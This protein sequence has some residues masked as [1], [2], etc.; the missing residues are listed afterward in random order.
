ME[1]T[2]SLRAALQLQVDFLESSDPASDEDE[3]FAWQ[4]MRADFEQ[5]LA[6]TQQDGESSSLKAS[7]ESIRNGGVQNDT[8]EVGE[9]S[10]AE[11]HSEGSEGAVKAFDPDDK[12]ETNTDSNQL[13][14]ESENDNTTTEAI[15]ETDGSNDGKQNDS[16]EKNTEARGKKTLSGR[17]NVLTDTDCSSKAIVKPPEDIDELIEGDISGPRNSLNPEKNRY[18]DCVGCFDKLNRD[19]SEA[20]GLECGH[21]WCMSCVDNMFR[22]AAKA[23]ADYPAKCC[24]DLDVGTVA[25]TRFEGDNAEPVHIGDILGQDTCTMY[26]KKGVEFRTPTRDRVYCANVDCL[27][28]IPKPPLGSFSRVWQDKNLLQCPRCLYDTCLSCKRLS[29]EHED[30]NGRCPDTA[31]KEAEE[32]QLTLDLAKERKWARCPG[33]EAVVEKNKGCKDMR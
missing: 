11:I 12:L 5:L 8:E 3:T 19:K 15:K 22:N 4:I 29:G 9:E 14:A 10:E 18:V 30:E 31:E 17:C 6:E 27:A 13:A 24:N 32:E 23:E 25:H 33:C 20:I 16:H 28:F 26:K 2:S 21:F 1:A 7:S